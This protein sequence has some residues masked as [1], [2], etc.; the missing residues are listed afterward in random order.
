MLKRIG[1]LPLLLAAALCLTNC[2]NG[3]RTV[4]EGQAGPAA[5][6]APSNSNAAG[7]AANA[8]AN[9]NASANANA[10]GRNDNVVGDVGDVTR[11]SFAK[12]ATSGT[13]SV[14]LPPGGVKRFA[15]EG[16]Y[17]QKIKV[18]AD[19]KDAV[20]KMISGTDRQV[21]SAG[22]GLVLRVTVGGDVIF[23]VRNASDKELTTTVR[24]EITSGS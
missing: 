3:G 7:T 15:V 4:N 2:G 14:T 8:A 6:A 10:P 21:E 16:T 19:S 18:S 22:G 11:I 1:G 23:E 9:T 20:V 17:A 24:V 12:G 13:A 5:N